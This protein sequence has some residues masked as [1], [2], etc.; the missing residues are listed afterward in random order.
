MAKVEYCITDG[1][2]FIKQYANGKWGATTNITIADVWDKRETAVAVLN[3]S[4]PLYM[5]ANLYVASLDTGNIKA[6]VTLSENE[7]SKVRR[8]VSVSKEKEFDLLRYS[9]D[10]DEDVQDMIRGFD[11]V[12]DVLKKYGDSRYTKQIGEKMMRANLVLEDVKHYHGRK[13][14]SSRDG[15][16]LNKLEDSAVIERISIKNQNEISKKLQRC[17]NDLFPIIDDICNFISELR[18]QKYIP[19]ILVD[20]FEN[21]NLDIDVKDYIEGVS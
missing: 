3:H 7:V 17:Y 5:R 16:R 12:R 9:F 4:I 13:A 6:Q 21:N 11:T 14:L 8:D 2:K 20:L 1:H 15:F 18:N 19:R 10:K